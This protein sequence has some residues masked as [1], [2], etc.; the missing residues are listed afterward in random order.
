MPADIMTEP[1]SQITAGDTLKWTRS[2]AD[3]PASAGWTLQYTLVSTTA[4]YSITATASGDDYAITVPASTTTAWAA[5]RYALTE[6]VTDGTERYTLATSTV[7]IAANL[8]A[9]LAGIDNR[10]HARKVLDSIEAWLETRAPVAGEIQLG[11]RRIRQYDLADLLALRDRYRA[12]VRRETS[13]AG[14][15]RLLVNL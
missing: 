13:L 8:A 4:A 7:M 1:P 2:L 9:A 3:Y 15:T 12:E 10:T 6:Y 14:G 11:E 5:G